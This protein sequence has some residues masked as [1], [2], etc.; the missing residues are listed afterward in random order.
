MKCAT[1]QRMVM[2]RDSDE[3]AAKKRASLERHLSICR[4]CRQFAKEYRTASE[5]LQALPAE[6]SSP[7]TLTRIRAQMEREAAPRAMGVVLGRAALAAAAAVV[8]VVAL[9]VRLPDESPEPGVGYAAADYVEA[10]E[11]DLLLAS[12]DS[13]IELLGEEVALASEDMISSELGAV[14]EALEEMMTLLEDM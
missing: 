3:L 14:E 13:E 2:L 4:G 10:S 12:L 9:A 6:E 5:A 11:I 1:W 7:A 8:I